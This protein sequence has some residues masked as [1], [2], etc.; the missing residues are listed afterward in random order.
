MNAVAKLRV[1]VSGQSAKAH[2]TIINSSSQDVYLE[3]YKVFD[4]GTVEGDLF[5]IT[6]EHHKI[7]YIG[8][9]VKRRT[10]IAAD[11]LKLAPGAVYE[12]TVDLSKVYEFPRGRHTYRVHYEAL[13]AY[14]NDPDDF[15]ELRSDDVTFAMSR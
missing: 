13:H 5:E 11:F 15:W 9:M 3:K 10:P 8:K 7:T 12:I 1:E 2:L 6:T 14:L 4:G